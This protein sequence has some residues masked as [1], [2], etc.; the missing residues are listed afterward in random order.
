MNFFSSDEYLTAL[1]DTW[2]PGR[3]ARIGVYSVGDRLFRL[4]ALDRRRPVV[5]DGVRAG[6]YHFLDFFEPLEHAEEQRGAVV[7]TVPWLPRVAL[8]AHEVTSPAHGSGSSQDGTPAL[9]VDWTRFRDWAAFEE[10]YLARRR[11]LLTDSRRRRRHL[12][13]RFGGIR[14]VWDDRRPEVFAAAIAWK[15]A[16][17]RRTAVR[18]GFAIPQ[19]VTMFRELWRRRLLVAASLTAGDR[20]VAVH[21]GALWNRRFFSWVPAYDREVSQQSPGRLLLE[22]LLRESQARGDVQFDFMIGDASYKYCYATHERL[23][24][25]LGKPPLPESVRKLARAAAKTA[26]SLYPPLLDRAR[27]LENAWAAAPGRRA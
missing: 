11:S 8:E 5:T 18:D 4:L 22:E 1:A 24:G 6:A 23:V 20:L 26:L 14:M 9:Y 3:T 25:P 27:A 17:Y 2:F 10:H 19:N 7:G 16:Q 21:L 12:E 13:A 15:S